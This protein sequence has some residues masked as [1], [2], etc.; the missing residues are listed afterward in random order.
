[1]EF[2]RELLQISCILFSIMLQSTY[3]AINSA[4][5]FLMWF[6]TIFEWPYYDSEF[7]INSIPL[8]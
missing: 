8:Y 4:S 1:M 7:I 2:L 5:T 6:S 3:D